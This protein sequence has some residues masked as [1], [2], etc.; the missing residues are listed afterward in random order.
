MK[1]LIISLLFGLMT[2]MGLAQEIVYQIDDVSVIN[3]GD[4]RL[5]FRQFNEQKTPLNGQHRIIDG[6]HSEC[7]V[8]EFTDGM[9]NGAFQ[10]LK[11]NKLKEDGT[12][13]EGR[14][15]GIFKEYN[16]DGVSV[17]K[18]TPYKDGKLNGIVTTYYT[19]GKPDKEKEYAMSVEH[20]IDRSYDYQTGNVSERNY[21]DGR[22]HG[23]QVIY[24]SSNIGDFVERSTYDNGKK[25]GYYSETFTDGTIKKQGQY[26]SEGKKYGKW[27][28]RDSF[29]AKDNDKFSGRLII[30]KNDEIVELEIIKDF[31]KFQRNK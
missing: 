22:Q 28:E 12:Y 11:N 2:L 10:H 26:N 4:G 14:K 19:N 7:I 25:V 6:Y 27:L 5:L 8:A 20:G 23:S 15:N 13:K 3:Y 31:A 17:K 1:R 18:E 30:Y 24:Y 9:Y 16:Y 29:S 21:K